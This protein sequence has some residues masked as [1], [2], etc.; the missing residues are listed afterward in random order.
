[1]LSSLAECCKSF[2]VELNF[3]FAPPH[4]GPN[5][6]RS[7]FAPCGGMVW[8]GW[9]DFDHKCSRQAA[10]DVFPVGVWASHY[11]IV[12]D[13]TW[14]PRS[15]RP[16][17]P[18]AAPPSATLTYYSLK[19]CWKAKIRCAV[20]P[21]IRKQR[22]EVRTWRR[23]H[24]VFRVLNAIEQRLVAWQPLLLPLLHSSCRIEGSKSLLR[25]PETLMT[26]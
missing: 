18:S 25:D 26:N 20:D 8:V 4:Q 5:Q 24:D 6:L 19:R 1:M 3:N 13:G 2:R 22:K 9:L 7:G 17:P 11:R 15:S 10:F 14:L 21:A 23:W 16:R 12:G